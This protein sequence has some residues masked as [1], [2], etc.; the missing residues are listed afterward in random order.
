MNRSRE[1][2]KEPT[3]AKFSSLQRPLNMGKKR[4]DS[5][6]HLTT[7]FQSLPSKFPLTRKSTCSSEKSR[8]SQKSEN[9]SSKHPSFK[10]YFGLDSRPEINNM[11]CISFKVTH[12]AGV[13]GKM[14]GNREE[15]LGTP[16]SPRTGEYFPSFTFGSKG[17]QLIDEKSDSDKLELQE[18][19]E[20]RDFDSLV[21]VFYENS[22]S[23]SSGKWVPGRRKKKLSFRKR[24]EKKIL[25]VKAK[26]IFKNKFFKKFSISGQ[27]SFDDPVK[28]NTL[29]LDFAVPKNPK[30]KLGQ[31]KNKNIN[32]N[33]CFDLNQNKTSPRQNQLNISLPNKKDIK[34]IKMPTKSP[35]SFNLNKGFTPNKVSYEHGKINNMIHGL[36]TSKIPT[37]FIDYSKINSQINMPSFEPDIPKIYSFEDL[38]KNQ[39]S[40]RKNSPTPEPQNLRMNK[41]NFSFNPSFMSNVHTQESISTLNGNQLKSV[42][43][44]GI[45]LKEETSCF[46]NK[47]FSMET[48]ETKTDSKFSNSNKKPTE[49]Q[50]FFSGNLAI[51][52]NVLN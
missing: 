28:T 38:P 10:N 7:P 17:G 48:L 34:N 9:S 47:I 35:R 51:N 22:V 4:E 8:S 49:M 45:Q 19:V 37:D 30:K 32:F 20:L 1:N 3:P 25:K 16:K 36:N 52:F 14:D 11:D 12:K 44:A 27:N 2:S 23:S 13:S 29:A 26:S 43:D 41:L 21:N 42:E 15:C 5:E 6:E 31:N 33:L 18:D 40:T 24:L 46:N 39:G 50:D